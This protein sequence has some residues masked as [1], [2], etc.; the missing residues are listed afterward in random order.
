MV[1]DWMV[2]DYITE[3][4]ALLLMGVVVVMVSK[5][6]VLPWSKGRLWYKWHGISNEI[7]CH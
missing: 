1:V 4:E 5:K 7:T 3:K 6:G 2:V